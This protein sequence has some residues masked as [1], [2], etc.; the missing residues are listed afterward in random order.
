MLSP[1][2]GDLSARGEPDPGVALGIVEEALDRHHPPGTPRQ[3]AM[4]PNA[5]HLRRAL[6]A[7]GVKRIKTVFEVI[8]ELIAGVKALRGCKAHIIGIQRI[9]DDQLLAMGGGQPIG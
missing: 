5:H 7:L 2:G 3:A 1:M 4:K 6:T 8:V 9:R